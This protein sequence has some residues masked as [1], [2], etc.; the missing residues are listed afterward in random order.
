MKKP[1]PQKAP[2]KRST[3]R[4]EKPAEYPVGCE[5]HIIDDEVP[6][7]CLVCGQPLASVVRSADISR[8]P[9]ERAGDRVS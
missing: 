1:K 2:K 7:T 5:C 3:K 4:P 6:L 8:D 9:A